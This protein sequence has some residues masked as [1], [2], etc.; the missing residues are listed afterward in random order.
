MLLIKWH[1]SMSSLLVLTCGLWIQ[2]ERGCWWSLLHSDQR[3][4]TSYPDIRLLGSYNRT[5]GFH[6]FVQSKRNKE[7]G[8]SETSYY[9]FYKLKGEH[10]LNFKLNECKTE[11]TS[12]QHACSRSWRLMVHM[13]FSLLKTK[14]GFSHKLTVTF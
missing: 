3:R 9:A 12:S 1:L 10:K 13:S 14:I 6:R 7:S 2:T 5:V 4:Q 8:T 11:C